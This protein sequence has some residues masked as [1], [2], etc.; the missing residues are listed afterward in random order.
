MPS[1][2][3]RKRSAARLATALAGAALVASSFV[4]SLPLASSHREAPLITQ[5]PAADNTDT[6]AFVSPDNPGTVTLVANYIPIEVPSGGPNFYPWSPDVL[7]EIHVDNVGDAQD[8]IKFQFRFKNNIQN[9][10]TFLYN[11][12]PINAETDPTYNFR[13]SYSVTRVDA[14]G[15]TVIADNV[16]VPPDNVGLKSLP[17]YDAVAAAAVTTTSNNNLVFAGQRAD[18]FFVDLRLFD[19]LNIRPAAQ[20]QNSLAGINVKTIAIQ[21]PKTQLT[22]DGSA[23]SDPNDPHS[24]VGV[25]A[26]ASRQTTSVVAPPGQTPDSLAAAGGNWVQVSRL[27]MPLVNEVVIPLGKKDLWNASVPS[28]DGQF[29]SYV[30]DPEL[31]KLL[32]GLFKINVPPSPRDD[33]VA[34]FLTGIKGLNM[35]ANV[36]PSEQIRLNMAIPPSASP[37]RLGLLAGQK[38]GFPNGRRLSDDVVDIALRAVCGS[39]YALFHSDFKPDAACATLGDGVDG[40]DKPYLASFPYVAAPYPGDK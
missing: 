20:A 39:T 35:P 34:I 33:L 16:P 29:L 5:D 28:A 3:I 30:T 13:Q 4:P 32:N 6:Y 2:P 19:L 15:A 10:G 21:V 25:W 11:T 22:S 26:T 1:I 14:N 38:D 40:P 27:G 18:P 24:I 8:H 37:D 12:G 9:G 17:N 36:K 7:Y 31:A 23:A